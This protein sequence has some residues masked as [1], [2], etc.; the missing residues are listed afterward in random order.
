MKPSRIPLGDD[1][2]ASVIGCAVMAGLIAVTATLLHVGSVVVARHRAQAAADLAAVAVAAALDRGVV[3][4]CEVSEPITSRMRVR[5]QRC[6]IDGW[7][8]LL[9]V[10]APVSSFFDGAEAKAVARAGPAAEVKPSGG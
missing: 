3:E 1:G 4:A 2:S 7:Y 5:L 6:E 10:A 9:E 8:V